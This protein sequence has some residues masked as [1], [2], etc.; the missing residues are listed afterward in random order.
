VGHATG[1]EAESILDVSAIYTSIIF[2]LKPAQQ[3]NKYTE[4]EVDKSAWPATGPVDTGFAAMTVSEVV[5]C[6]RRMNGINEAPIEELLTL[7]VR[8]LALAGV[9]KWT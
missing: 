6:A 3:G 1:N 8:L 4:P 7:R 2:A 9:G 5:A